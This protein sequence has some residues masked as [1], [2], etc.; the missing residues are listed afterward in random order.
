MTRTWP[1]AGWPGGVRRGSGPAGTQAGAG[2]VP[3]RLR[4]AGVGGEPG[5]HRYDHVT[6]RMPGHPQRL[7]EAVVGMGRPLGIPVP[8]PT[9]RR[10]PPALAACRAGRAPGGAHHGKPPGRDTDRTRTP[11]RRTYRAGTGNPACRRARAEC[12]AESRPPET[13]TGPGHQPDGHTGPAPATPR[14]A[15]PRRSASRKA[16][17]PRHRPDQDTSRTDMPNRHRQPRVPPSPGGVH[18]GKPPGREAGGS[19]ARAVPVQVGTPCRDGPRSGAVRSRWACRW[20]R[21]FRA[22]PRSPG[23]G[24]GCSRRSR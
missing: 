3:C 23:G 2:R 20:L 17:R 24:R 7:H 6:D 13:Q 11:A 15:E 5:A 1:R 19:G 22:V 21:R 9:R 18:R 10:T 16:A 8:G 14:A 12:I 4:P